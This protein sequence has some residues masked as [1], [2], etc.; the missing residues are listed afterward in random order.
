MLVDEDTPRRVGLGQEMMVHVVRAQVGGVLYGVHAGCVGIAR[1]GRHYVPVCQIQPTEV[2]STP[3]L[4]NCRYCESAGVTLGV[5][6]M[7]SACVRTS[8]CTR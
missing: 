3:L 7:C 5:R 4:A 8:H 2:I 1:S 6:P